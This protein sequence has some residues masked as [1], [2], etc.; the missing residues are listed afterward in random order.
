MNDEL[1]PVSKKNESLFWEAL[2]RALMQ[3]VGEKGELLSDE[4]T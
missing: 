4:R 3:A 2:V 1:L